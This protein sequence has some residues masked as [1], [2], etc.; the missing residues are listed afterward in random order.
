M[1]Q[2]FE[3]AGLDYDA[4]I[5]CPTARMPPRTCRALAITAAAA[6]ELAGCVF[7]PVAVDT[8]DPR[9][10]AFTRHLELQP[11]QLAAFRGCRD[12]GCV[13]LVVAAAATAAASAIVSGS[14]VLVGNV[15]YW[16]ER[17]GGCA[18]PR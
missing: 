16:I 17:Q 2:A 9:C 1:H 6:T 18:A 5:P 7:V 11:V 14:V 3:P 12:Q 10:Q 15:A 8:P 13:V 4:R